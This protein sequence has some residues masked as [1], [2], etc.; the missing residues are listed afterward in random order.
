[1]K[2]TVSIIVPVYNGEATIH[3]CLDSL[4]AQTY[5]ADLYDIIIV[6]NGSTDRTVEVVTGYSPRVQLLRSS[7][8]GPAAARNLGISGSQADII[9][10]TDAD[11]IADANWLEELVSHYVQPHI[12]GV[13]GKIEAYR[14]SERNA[15]E[16]FSDENSPLINFESGAGEFLP[17]LY[18]ANASYRRSLLNEAGFFNAMMATGE[19]VELSWRVQL[20]CKARLSYNEKAVVY[21]RH[22]SNR[23]KLAKQY[24]Q[25][26]FGEILLDTMFRQC[27]GYPRTL[28]FQLKRIWGQCRA[29]LRYVL[30]ILVRGLRLRLG[31]TSRDEA[32]KPQLLFLIEA[33]NILGKLEALRMTRFMRTTSDVFDHDMKSYIK[34]FY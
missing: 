29:L 23:S 33:N 26:G 30:S 6:E 27:P 9:A 34:R 8:R 20:T 24:R 13:G 3:Q 7:E 19:D 10:F 17:H 32:L 11:C 16:R 18:T 21:H 14:H 22:R 4:L 25:Y 5:P 28:G 15:I 31:L 12:G 1:L 2:P